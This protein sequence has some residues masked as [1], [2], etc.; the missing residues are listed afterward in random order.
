[1]ITNHSNMSEKDAHELL[2]A[3]REKS[4]E[5]GFQQIGVTNTDLNKHE[6][7]YQEWIA[8]G[9]HGEL[10]YMQNHGSKR[11]KPKELIP[12]TMRVLS[13]RMDYFSDNLDPQTILDDQNK[14]YIS[15]YSLGRD[16]HKLIRNRLSK[17]IK[18][19]QDSASNYDYRAFV[20]SAPVLERALA[21]K[22]GL[23]WFGK[24]TMLLNRSAG[25][26]FFLGE[27]YTNLPLPLDPPYE[28]EHCGSCT[29]CLDICPTKAF[30]GPYLLDGRKCISY[31]TIELKG[32]IPEELR[33]QMG[34]RIFGCDDCHLYALGTDSANIQE[35]KTSLPGTNL[36]TRSS[37]SCI[38]GTRQH[39]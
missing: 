32:A 30:E 15:R 10:D 13:L 25:S 39:S 33:S 31:L 37:L 1:M 38:L 17:L 18:F 20:D 28:K 14:A 35:N 16:Y 22:A 11:W 3:I 5:L 7:Y 29:A 19:I 34:N 4:K 26:W 27:I 8:K 9:F 23:G 36:M 6:E 2:V 24:N 21:Q 12:G